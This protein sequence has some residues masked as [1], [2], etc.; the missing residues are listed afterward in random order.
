MPCD[1]RHLRWRPALVLAGG[2]ASRAHAHR[3]RPSPSRELRGRRRGRRH[4]RERQARLLRDLRLR[5]RR[6]PLSPAYSSP[7]PSRSRRRPARRT[8]S[9][10]SRW[11]CSAASAASRVRSWA[12]CMLGVI[13]SIGATFVGDGW[14]VFIG[15][16][17]GPVVLVRPAARS[18]RQREGCLMGRRGSRSG[19]SSCR[20]RGVSCSP[21]VI[22]ASQSWSPQSSRWSDA[23][24]LWSST[25]C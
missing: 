5:G 14:R 3:F 2:H 7:S 15:C 9:P 20:A 10:G 25:R 8:S 6:L 17:R 18:L 21:L 13:E 11:S 4:G 19:R 1:L 16:P 12:A 24:T 22:V 23:T